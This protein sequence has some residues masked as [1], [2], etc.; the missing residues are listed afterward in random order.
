MTHIMLDIET[1][2]TGSNSLVLSIGAVEFSL[3]GT[4]FRQ[5]SVNLPILEQIINPTVEVDMD[6]IKWWKSQ[7]AEAKA[8]LL[9]KKPCKSVKEGLKAFH[10]FIK[11]F[12]NPVIWG[13]GC[14]FDNVIMRNLFKSFNL[15][16]PTPF[17]T[18]MDVR[19]VVQLADYEKVNKLTGKFTGTK[20]DAI[21]DCLHQVKLVSNGYKLLK[22]KE[23]E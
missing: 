9:H 13:N 18:D 20:H 8:A 22:G 23:D 19:T 3:S 14:T 5:F 4:T 21:A 12:E 1:L 11:T 17:Y 15:D 7:S 6:T 16:F 2:G 10:D